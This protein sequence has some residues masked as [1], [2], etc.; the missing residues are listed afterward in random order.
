MII[1]QASDFLPQLK[2]KED[3]LSLVQKEISEEETIFYSP[4]FLFEFL[5]NSKTQNKA[6]WIF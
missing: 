1:L 3:K 6:S 2:F 4:Q 5:S